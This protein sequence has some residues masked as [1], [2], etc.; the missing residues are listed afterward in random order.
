MTTVP[1]RSGKEDKDEDRPF[2]LWLIYED[3]LLKK[4][5]KSSNSFSGSQTTRKQEGSLKIISD[6]PA[7]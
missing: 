7:I 2:Y 6:N 1:G 5:K 4:K 3:L